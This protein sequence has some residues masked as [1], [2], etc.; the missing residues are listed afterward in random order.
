MQKLSGQTTIDEMDYY[1]PTFALIETEDLTDDEKNLR[2][3]ADTLI[4]IAGSLR[5]KADEMLYEQN[6][7]KHKT[8]LTPLRQADERNRAIIHDPRTSKTAR[9]KAER[10]CD[11]IYKAFWGIM[12]YGAH[13]PAKED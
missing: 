12:K 10:E 6:Y 7:R 3:Q 4:D 5:S 1:Y 8:T 11:K 13:A 2:I 9:E